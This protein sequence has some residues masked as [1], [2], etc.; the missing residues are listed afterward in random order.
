ME[1][2]CCL[3]KREGRAEERKAAQCRLLGRRHGW[4]DPGGGIFNSEEGKK[5]EILGYGWQ[6]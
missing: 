3:R 5:L 4:L 1:L 2:I 6:L